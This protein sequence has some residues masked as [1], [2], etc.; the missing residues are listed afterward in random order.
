MCAVSYD[1]VLGSNR[2]RAICVFP[3]FAATGGE[4]RR[5]SRARGRITHITR[6][7]TMHPHSSP[8]HHRYIT[9]ITYITYIVAARTLATATAALGHRRP[10]GARAYRDTRAAS[11]RA[12]RRCHSMPL[13]PPAPLHTRT[14]TTPPTPPVATAYTE[15]SVGRR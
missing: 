11:R 12:R 7:G 4:L 2:W 10:G 8:T 9:Y 3:F 14:P 6:S 13:A 1:R 15:V 5:L